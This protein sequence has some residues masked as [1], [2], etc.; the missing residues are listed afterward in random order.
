M[1]RPEFA[2]PIFDPHSLGVFKN[3]LYD[4]YKPNFEKKIVRRTK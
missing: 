3:D 1:L 4:S 2:L